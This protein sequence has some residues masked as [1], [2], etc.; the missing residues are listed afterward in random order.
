MSALIE[1]ANIYMLFCKAMSYSEFLKTIHLFSVQALIFF[2]SQVRTCH[3][4]GFKESKKKN[5]AVTVLMAQQVEYPVLC[6]LYCLGS[7]PISQDQRN[8]GVKLLHLT[9]RRLECNLTG[10]LYKQKA[11]GE[12]IKKRKSNK[13]NLLPATNYS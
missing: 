3:F 11:M 4:L 7:Q 5:E 9:R 1:N 6:L 8:V 2:F 10:I 13:K 12:S